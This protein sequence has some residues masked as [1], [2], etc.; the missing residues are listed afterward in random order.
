[1]ARNSRNELTAIQSGKFH[2][3]VN[4]PRQ[5]VVS[6][7]LLSDELNILDAEI[8]RSQALVLQY[9]ADL[10]MMRETSE[11]I[12]LC[13]IS[14]PSRFN[15]IFNASEVDFVMPAAIVVR[16][17]REGPGLIK[18]PFVAVLVILAVT[19]VR[20]IVLASLLVV[21][22]AIGVVPAIPAL[23]GIGR[24]HESIP[25]NSRWHACRACLF[26]CWLGGVIH[27]Q[28]QCAMFDAS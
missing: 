25:G 26:E 1:M 20:I 15:G 21:A 3:H 10:A 13:R 6:G 4:V 9:R 7:N 28:R 27:S 23:L 14:R 24:I 17:L 12:A 19:P 22:T 8:L 11:S 16:L 2:F 5:H 18:L